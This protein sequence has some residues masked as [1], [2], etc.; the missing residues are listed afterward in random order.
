MMMHQ[1]LALEPDTQTRSVPARTLS[2][3]RE[4]ALGS[5]PR[6]RS[7]GRDDGQTARDYNAARGSME[8]RP[9]NLS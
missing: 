1:Q 8:S 4:T 2:D 3:R 7:H 5:R 6:S 9:H